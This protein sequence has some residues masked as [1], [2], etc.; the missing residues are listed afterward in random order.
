MSV[1][2][3]CQTRWVEGV[4]QLVDQ[5]SL[6]GQGNAIGV[7]YAIPRAASEHRDSTSL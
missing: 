4:G 6:A 5:A 1:T 7:C 3:I 2:Q